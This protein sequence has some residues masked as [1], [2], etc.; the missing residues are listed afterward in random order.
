MHVHMIC[1]SHNAL[2]VVAMEE[3]LSRVLTDHYR[4]SGR[5]CLNGLGVLDCW[6]QNPTLGGMGRDLVVF[7]FSY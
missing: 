2:R 5:E 6:F 1:K 7:L 3:S 4:S